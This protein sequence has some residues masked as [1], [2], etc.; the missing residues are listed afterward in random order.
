MYKRTHIVSAFLTVLVLIVTPV[1]VHATDIRIILDGEYVD[2]EPAPIIIDERILVPARAITEMLGGNIGWDPEGR[3]ASLYHAPSS[4]LIFLTI[5]SSIAE[6]SSP[7]PESNIIITEV[8]LDVPVQII[9]GRMMVPLR[10]ISDHFDATTNFDY[11]ART[12]E[13]YTYERYD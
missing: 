4:T 1:A 2:V 8:V 5:G 10:F 6:V 9:D 7:G 13:V 3:I 12:V 11:V